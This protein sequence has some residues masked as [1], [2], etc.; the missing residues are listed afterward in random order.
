MIG[1]SF[2][3]WVIHAMVLRGIQGATVLNAVI[4]LAKV[5]P[6]L[7]FVGLVAMAFQVST[8]RLDFWGSSISIDVDRGDNS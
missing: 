4:T 6:L 5:V 7:L 8:F 2:V 3:L 1:A